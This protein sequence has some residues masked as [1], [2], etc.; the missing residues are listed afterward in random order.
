MVP[1]GEVTL[2]IALIG[3]RMKLISPV[4]YA[5]LLFVITA[6][7]LLTPA[8]LRLLFRTTV[9]PAKAAAAHV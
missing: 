9:A 2:V 6:T 8:L 1:R 5:V 7:T 4:F 3:L